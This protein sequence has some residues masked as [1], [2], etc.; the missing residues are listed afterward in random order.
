MILFRFS[1]V[2]TDRFVLSQ[3]IPFYLVDTPTI[4]S[5]KLLGINHPLREL[6]Q[7]GCRGVSFS[8]EQLATDP[9]LSGHLSCFEGYFGYTGGSRY[10]GTVFRLPLRKES[11]A[12]SGGVCDVTG[13][14]EKLLLPLMEEAESTLLFLKSVS[15]IEIL[16]RVEHATQSL[17]RAE[18]PLDYRHIVKKYRKDVTEFVSSREY[19]TRT[20]LFVCLFPTISSRGGNGERR[21]KV[22]LVLNLI[23]FGSPNGELRTFYCEQ[24][25]NYLPWVG[26]GLATGV[27]DLSRC[28]SWGF[29]W[30]DGN[31]S[32][33]FESIKTT[34]S[35]PLIVDPE[36][37]LEISTG[38][39]F[40]FLPTQLESKFPF[41]VH[42]YFSL[43]SNRRSVNWP[44]PDNQN[45]IE[46]KWNQLLTQNLTSIAYAA[47]LH[48]AVIALEH[49]S[50]LVY[51]YK[52]LSRWSPHE[53]EH[54][55][56]S[57]ILCRGLRKLSK[58]LLLFSRQEGGKWLSINEAIFLPSLAG[59][60][61]SHEDVCLKLFE[62]LEQP[63]VDVPPFISEII[64]NVPEIFSQIQERILAPV[65]IRNLLVEFYSS[66]VCREYIASDGVCIALLDILLTYVSTLESDEL[67]LD[68]V[69]LLPIS[70][71]N[72]PH[73]FRYNG[74]TKYFISNNTPTHLALFPGL[75]N[76]F[77]NHSIPQRLHSILLSLARSATSLNLF[78]LTNLEKNPELF[79][80][81]LTKSLSCLFRTESLDS[82]TW[83]PGVGNQPP[84][85]WIVRLYHFIGS[86]QSLLSAV[87]RLPI[88]PQHSTADDVITLIP[89]QS[90]CIYIEICSNAN[91]K[92]LE[93]ILELSGCHLCVNQPFIE[94]FRKFVLPPIPAG[95]IQALF[96]TQIVNNFL[97]Q[98]PQ[99]EDDK[100]FQLID[101]LIPYAEDSFHIIKQLPVFPNTR[102]EWLALHSDIILPPL[103]IPSDILYPPHF[104]SPFKS[105]V[106]ILYE[107]LNIPPISIECFLKFHLLPFLVTPQDTNARNKLIVFV[108]E[109]IT[110][111]N[112]DV[113]EVGA[114]LENTEWIA[115]ATTRN[116]LHTPSSLLDP[117]DSLFEKLLLPHSKS[118]F[119][120]DICRNHFDVMK[121]FLGMNSHDTLSLDLLVEVCQHSVEA[122]KSKTGSGWKRTFSALLDLLSYYIDTFDTVS[123]I[124]LFTIFTTPFIFLDQSPP[125]DWPHCAGFHTSNQLCCPQDVV[126]CHPDSIYLIGSI[127]PTFS[128]S[129]SYPKTQQILNRMGVLPL[130]IEMTIRQLN[131]LSQREIDDGDRGSVYR[132]VAKIYNY[133]NRDV[134][135]VRDLESNIIFIPDECKF[136]SRESVVFV[137]PFDL[138]P[139]LYSIRQLRYESTR[140]FHFLEINQSPSPAQLSLILCK[141]YELDARLSDRQLKIV[142]DIL[143]YFVEGDVPQTEL[144]I[145]IPGKDLRLYERGDVKLVFW[146]HCWLERGLI[147]EDFVIVHG[148]I[149]NEMAYK[150]GVSPFSERVAP[151]SE[152]FWC[153]ESGQ[154]VSVTDRLRSILEAY[155]G[156]INVLKEMLQNADDARATEMKVVFDWREHPT[157]TLLNTELKDWQGPAILFY[158]NSTFSDK[159][160]RNIVKIDGA[161][162]AEDGTTIGRYGLGFCTV[163]HFTDVPSFVS[164]NYVHIFDP[165]KRYLRR[166]KGGC[167]IDFCNG[168]YARYIGIYRDQ[169]APFKGIFDCDIMNHHSFNGT[170]FRLPI[171]SSDISSDVSLNRFEHSDIIHLQE[172]FVREA[173]HLLFFTQCIKSIEI[174]DISATSQNSELIHA[175]RRDEIS[176]PSIPHSFLH[177]NNHLVELL[178]HGQPMTPAVSHCEYK[179]TVQSG[180]SMDW[181]V[182]FATGSGACVEVLRNLPYN[183]APLPFAGVAINL[184]LLRRVEESDYQSTLYCFFPLPVSTSFPFHCHAMFE[185]RHDR[186]GLVDSVESK[187]EWNKVL[188]SD[189]LVLATLTLY[190]HLA[191]KVKLSNDE[192]SRNAYINILYKMFARQVLSDPLWAGF[193]IAISKQ[194]SQSE[195][196][197]FPLNKT[198]GIDWGN[199]SS[200]Y[201]LNIS[202]IKS[203]LRELWS[204]S[205]SIK[206]LNIVVS[207]G[208]P[209]AIIPDSICENSAFLSLLFQSRT[210]NIIDLKMFTEFF[211]SNLSKFRIDL[212]VDIL[213][214]LISTCTVHIWLRESIMSTPCIPC[215]EVGTFRK[216]N[217]VVDPNSH[218]VAQLYEK[219]ENR[220]PSDVCIEAMFTSGPVLNVLRTNLGLITSK[221]SNEELKGRAEYIKAN[222]NRELAV[223]LIGYL[224]QK[225][226]TGSEV[227]EM[228]SVIRNVAFIPVECPNIAETFS[229]TSNFFS[230]SEI[231]PILSE[232]YC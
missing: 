56:F 70:G 152:D 45:D 98:L 185:L 57:S 39:L 111:L 151:P 77:V 71:S 13:V 143:N 210:H 130:S 112:F 78:D 175:V 213:T 55:L 135:Q 172:S 48:I 75:E 186:Q 154:Q 162:K 94:C 129:F 216:P 145:Y 81:L 99:V 63:I 224:D 79:S 176:Q 217:K 206:L 178:Y 49:P 67:F 105:S 12:I 30:N 10:E 195:F 159:D 15:S 156:N 19:L 95:L 200:T 1:R 40:C 122:L 169:F 88:L 16:E 128:E 174:Y 221:L 173:E 232:T 222:C 11:S 218:L 41:H 68:S 84:V 103:L 50:P 168:E 163:Y 106:R 133:L 93:Q 144:Q 34:F 220:L 31:P 167:K 36:T 155:S 42:S 184:D 9:S 228:R 212:I 134:S 160:F 121:S 92:W 64:L 37:E 197:L 201:F 119:P 180:Q 147:E 3:S 46:P 17:F 104:I 51:H 65:D 44:A 146:D 60:S 204:H 22:W 18:I 225:I 4:L 29:E 199:F 59:K 189:A 209:V 170:L 108:L 102:G 20:K 150:L 138:T 227:E 177:A 73:L 208:Y 161:T 125:N 182:T 164:R 26:L 52:L 115:D 82:I 219:I 83:R 25:L 166:W 171:R 158:N 14:R 141:F 117:R 179:L 24:N 214:V 230:P 114:C 116:Y 127:T 226:F 198:T 123:L 193:A 33:L 76:S 96:S 132:M 101:I 23:G 43:S 109:N 8:I 27:R 188:V 89:L 223:R 149:S 86:S 187:T 72:Q 38:R 231:V 118:L 54:T 183:V 124:K 91:L 165:Q 202:S 74:D 85:S 90:Q 61:L 113:F 211:F 205:F 107:K 6:S 5:D 62:L 28:K 203:D 80:Q 196:E 229:I 97:S 192:V 7:P 100:M 153:E 191:E 32:M 207:C 69:P 131:Y 140:F 137:T 215:G 87:S 53:P 120:S 139:Y 66:P 58:H 21:E 157:Q 47:F 194:F 136:V 142:I 148:S 35:N 2:Q 126:L 190:Q 181:I 110:K